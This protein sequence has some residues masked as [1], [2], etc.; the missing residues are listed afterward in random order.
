MLL[1]V[2]QMKLFL[3]NLNIIYNHKKQEIIYFDLLS[4]LIHTRRAYTKKLFKTE[5][6]VIY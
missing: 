1:G 4:I 2:P 5:K 6:M 3:T